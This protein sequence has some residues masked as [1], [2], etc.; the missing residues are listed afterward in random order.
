[1]DERDLGPRE[2]RSRHRGRGGLAVGRRDDRA[3]VAQPRREAG[4]RMRLQAR[5][6]LAGQAGA[7]APSSP[8]GKLADG[9]RREDLGVER[10]H[11]AR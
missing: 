6:H 10:G 3:A 5:E 11:D 8:A 4:D 2:D 7:A 9:S 1:V